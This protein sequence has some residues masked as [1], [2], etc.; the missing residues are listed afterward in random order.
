MVLMAEK[1]LKDSSKDKKKDESVVKKVV[2]RVH[3][4]NMDVHESAPPPYEHG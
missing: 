1:G 3:D 4:D 2:G